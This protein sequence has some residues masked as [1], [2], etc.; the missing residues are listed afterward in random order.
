MRMSRKDFKIFKVQIPDRT[1]IQ[2]NECSLL[3]I[4]CQIPPLLL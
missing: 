3:V 4:F 2:T 1:M